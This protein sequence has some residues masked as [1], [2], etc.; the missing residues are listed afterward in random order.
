MARLSADAFLIAKAAQMVTVSGL[1][2]ANVILATDYTKT[3]I[4]IQNV[5]P[6]ALMD[7]VT[8]RTYAPAT[9]ATNWTHKINTNAFQYV[10]MNVFTGIAFRQMCASV[11]QV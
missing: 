4:A 2:S 3:A 11:I 7:H 1:I 8:N 10:R 9:V 6:D 5:A